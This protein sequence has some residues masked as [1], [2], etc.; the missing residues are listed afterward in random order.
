LPVQVVER[1]RDD[2]LGDVRHDDDVGRVEERAERLPIRLQRVTQLRE[3]R[4]RREDAPTPR[5]VR[6]RE[7]D[8]DPVQ[9]GIPDRVVQPERDESGDGR[10]RVAEAGGGVP[11]QPTPIVPD[12]ELMLAIVDRDDVVG[13]PA[14]QRAAIGRFRDAANAMHGW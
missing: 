2:R 1:G 13:R 10:A 4:R 12:A 14:R 8:L 9:R 5:P 11:A 7:T 3:V 6:Q